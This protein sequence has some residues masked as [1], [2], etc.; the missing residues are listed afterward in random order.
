MSQAH[1]LTHKSLLL[2]YF[3]HFRK[4]GVSVFSLHASELHKEERRASF[5]QMYIVHQHT[6][7]LAQ[8]SLYFSSPPDWKII[9]D[10]IHLVAIYGANKL[11]PEKSKSALLLG[12]ANACA[13]QY[14]LVLSSFSSACEPI[15]F[16]IESGTRS[17]RTRL[18]HF[19]PASFVHAERRTP[20][21]GKKSIFLC[22]L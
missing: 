10:H 15:F 19:S 20:E 21:C 13:A 3:R 4:W 11:S 18:G 5:L 1:G 9:A 22:V 2:Y 16:L 8:T 17:R 14:L 7:S 12:G 6:H